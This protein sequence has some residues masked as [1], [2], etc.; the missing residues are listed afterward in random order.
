MNK[1]QELIMLS[2]LEYQKRL[3]D[4]NAKLVINLSVRIRGVREL[5]Y[6]TNGGYCYCCCQGSIECEPFPYPCPTIKALDG[7]QG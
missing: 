2:D 6:K 3:N 1:Q 7:K 5:H 4:M